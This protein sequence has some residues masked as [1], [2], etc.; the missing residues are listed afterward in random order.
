MAGKLY[1]VGVGPGDPELLTL[2]ALRLVK[3]ADVIALPE[4]FWTADK[5]QDNC[6]NDTQKSRSCNTFS[7]SLFIL[8][9]APLAKADSEAACK[10]IDKA[11][12]KINDN[13]G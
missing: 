2:K 4:I 1:G 6:E 7:H 10:T 8:C 3:E 12:Y 5:C 9:A 11:E 13:T